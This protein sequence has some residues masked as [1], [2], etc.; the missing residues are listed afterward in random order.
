MLTN[1]EFDDYLKNY[2]DAFARM[3][4]KELTAD[5]K[6]WQALGDL[7]EPYYIKTR[8]RLPRPVSEIAE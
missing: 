2:D 3:I 8:V 6:A 5:Q 4:E 7:P 1:A